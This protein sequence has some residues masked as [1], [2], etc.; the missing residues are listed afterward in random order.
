MAGANDPDGGTGTRVD[1]SAP[2]GRRPGERANTILSPVDG[3]VL[4]LYGH[5]AG[6]L[7]RRRSSA[8]IDFAR[9]AKVLG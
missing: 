3:G 8:R 5:A 2:D 1:A 4:A 6:R 9:S 7:P